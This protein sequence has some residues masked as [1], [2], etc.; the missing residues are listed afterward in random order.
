M[1]DENKEWIKGVYRSVLDDYIINED[2]LFKL[3]NLRSVHKSDDVTAFADPVLNRFYSCFTHW[4]VKWTI[5][6]D[7]KIPVQ[8]EGVFNLYPVERI[9]INWDNEFGGNSWAPDMKGFRPLDMFYESAGCVG[10]YI[11][12]T[13][14][15]GLY[16]YEFDGETYP[17]HINFEGYLKLLSMSKGFGWWQSTLVELSTGVPQSNVDDFKE[18]MPQI[19]PDFNY[20]EFAALYESLRIDK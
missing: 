20:D 11:N 8:A 13:N 12:R 1:K 10:F 18:K 16:L 19:F 3:D 17:L 6:K 4:N 7:A 9:F 15:E 5:R 14:K 2:D